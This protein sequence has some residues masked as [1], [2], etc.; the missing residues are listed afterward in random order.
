MKNDDRLV[1]IPD[2]DPFNFVFRRF[3]VGPVLFT[4]LAASS[5][6][7][8]VDCV[9]DLAQRFLR[10]VL[11]LIG[12]LTSRRG[13]KGRLGRYIIILMVVWVLT[14]R[15]VVPRE[16]FVLVSPVHGWC[17]LSGTLPGRVVPVWKV[18]VIPAG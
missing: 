11:K 16:V 2:E 8:F 14:L 3:T 18:I 15:V 6:V 9:F 10:R 5:S 13:G 12:D 4:F 17:W 7:R 1:Q